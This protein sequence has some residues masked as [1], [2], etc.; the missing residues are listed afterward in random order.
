M[1]LLQKLEEKNA[2]K[3]SEWFLKLLPYKAKMIQA[4][5]SG[6]ATFIP[7]GEHLLRNSVKVKKTPVIRFRQIS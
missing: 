7:I 3:T 5:W 1:S 2:P 4:R 6:Q